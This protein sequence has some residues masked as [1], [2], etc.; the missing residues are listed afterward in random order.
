MP[1]YQTTI[2]PRTTSTDGWATVANQTVVA[3]CGQPRTDLNAW[4]RAGAPVN[5]SGTPVAIG[6]AGAVPCPYLT[7]IYDAAATV[8]DATDP[9][10]WKAATVLTGDGVHPNATGHALMAAAINTAPFVTA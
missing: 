8:E 10:K 9:T 3:G 7:G 4:L 5:G 1:V 6:T 2:T